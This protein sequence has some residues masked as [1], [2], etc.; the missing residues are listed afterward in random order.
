MLAKIKIIELSKQ[1][2]H[3][4]LQTISSIEVKRVRRLLF[5]I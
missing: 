5:V 4:S 1:F 3:E 2:R